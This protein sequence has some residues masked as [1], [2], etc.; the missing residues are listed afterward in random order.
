LN[1]RFLFHLSFSTVF[2]VAFT[3]FRVIFYFKYNS[4]IESA[5][6]WEITLAFLKGIQFDLSAIGMTL[7]GFWLLS[8]LQFL[9]RFRF[10]VVLWSFLPLV[11][12]V[13][14]IGHLSGDVIY[15]E[16]ANKHIGYEA[17]VFIGRDL[18]FIIY[19][20]LMNE[21]ISFLLVLGILAIY[22]IGIVALYKKYF[23]FEYRRES[24][25]RTLVN[26][27]L[28]AVL[29]LVLIRGGFQESPLRAS[30]AIV[31]NDR[32]VN[33]IALNGV[34]TAVM[35]VKSQKIPSIHK[36]DLAQAALIVR[37]EIDYKGAVWV[38]HPRYP[39]LRRKLATNPGRPPDIILVLLESWTGKYVSPISDGYFYG[40]EV[41]PY[42]NK[43]SKEGRVYTRFFANGGR[44]TNGLMSVLTGIP[45]RPGLTAMR[46]HQI[47]SQFS[48]IGSILRSLG[49]YTIFINGDDLSFDNVET[50]MPRWGFQKVIGKK[51]IAL[52]GKYKLG[53]W[54]F[55]DRDIFSV[56]EEEIAKAN[57]EEP[58]L[59][60][61]LT[62]TTHYPYIVPDKRFEIF[63]SDLKDSDYLNT[64]YYA[65]WSI[66][67]F[68]QSYKKSPRFPNTIFIFVGDH[69][70]HRYLNYYED[71]NI[72]FLM[73]SPT[74]IRPM[75]DN[76]IAGQ[77]DILPTI[78]GFVGKEVYFSSMGKDLLD[79]SNTNSSTYFAY[80]SAFGWIE[81]DLFYFQDS[82]R[83]I[84]LQFTVNPPNQENP[85]CRLNPLPCE[86]HKLKAKAF[87]NLSVEIL[88]QD[89]IFPIDPALIPNE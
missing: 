83:S 39:I 35:D 13:W 65:D 45:D 22:G 17:F 15:F 10:F 88:N 48:A 67:D 5:S 20:F 4:R 72:P 23:H 29:V 54:G 43:L 40:K 2:L 60:V 42:F 50:I 61:V 28:T 47:L 75:I 19:N 27:F 64:L 41:T 33:N 59:G 55:D 89:R 30:D 16:H 21:P 81:D 53:G 7:G 70:H 14:I 34:F 77:I 38:N 56:L 82:D 68:L 84:S 66:Y 49:Y 69:T 85:I 80:G 32:L 58:L 11:L 9:N 57:P 79:P 18:L 76:R 3:L 44:T 73:Y 31:C 6:S 37:K 1:H 71:R 24:P 78:L 62:M 63:S 87:F 8:T 26:F 52:T 36:M 86:A 74:K 12:F 51:E 46:T 25:Y